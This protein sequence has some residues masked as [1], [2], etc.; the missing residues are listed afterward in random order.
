MRRMSLLWTL[1]VLGSA[2]AQESADRHQTTSNATESR[3]L[4]H[5]LDAA[6]DQLSALSPQTLTRLGLRRVPDDLPEFCAEI[7]GYLGN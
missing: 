6:F 1:C 2:H 5:F 4:D 7:I 3:N